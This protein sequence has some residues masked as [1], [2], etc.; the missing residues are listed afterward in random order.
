[1]Y[2]IPMNQDWSFLIGNTLDQVCIGQYNTQLH[3]SG[4]E[5]CISIN[6]DQS[7]E[8]MNHKTN[9]T[10]SSSVE[11]MPGKSVTLI[12]LLGASVNEVIAENTSTL[13][14]LFNNNDE[15]RI[16]DSDDGYESFT[17]TSPNGLIVV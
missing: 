12:S 3:F 9:S 5:V 2:K 14:I 11:G 15:L 4:G 13:A 8:Y 1:M 7:N 10:T 6:Y 16:F 17:I